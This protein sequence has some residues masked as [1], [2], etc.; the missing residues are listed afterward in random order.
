MSCFFCEPAES[1]LSEENQI[2]K[3]HM[4]PDRVVII[5]WEHTVKIDLMLEFTRTA[6]N[7]PVK[8]TTWRVN[9]VK[10]I[11]LKDCQIDVFR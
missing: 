2:F 7:R 4:F 3:A 6:S 5:V 9:H 10:L 11:A 8:M 1:L